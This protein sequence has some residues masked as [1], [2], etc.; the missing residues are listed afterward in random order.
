MFG[1]ALASELRS[2]R[3]QLFLG[4]LGSEVAALG[5]PVR[6]DDRQGDVVAYTSGRLRVEEVAGRGL[7]ELEHGGVLERRRVGHVD[8]HVGALE[9]VSQTSPVSVFTPELG[10]AARA[11]WPWS[12][13]SV[14]S[15]EPMRPLPPMT[16]SFMMSHSCVLLDG[17]LAFVLLDGHLD[18][19]L[20]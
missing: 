18:R 13:S 4:G 1:T 2:A 11:S 5:Q 9:R 15:F 12:R 17:K 7:E 6:P 10:E 8:D 14:T 19:G 20:R 16:T 3:D